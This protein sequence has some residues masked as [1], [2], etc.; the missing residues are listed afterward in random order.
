MKESL[1][2]H[3]LYLLEPN[4]K[5]KQIL[6]FPKQMKMFIFKHKYYGINSSNKLAIQQQMRRDA[7]KKMVVNVLFNI[8]IEDMKSGV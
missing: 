7:V 5:I 3:C 4:I 6:Q 1:V 2:L 8:Y